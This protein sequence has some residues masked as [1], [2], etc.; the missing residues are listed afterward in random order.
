MKTNRVVVVVFNREISKN[1]FVCYFNT[2]K[3]DLEIFQKLE[4]KLREREFVIV[5][6]LFIFLINLTTISILFLY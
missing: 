2:H 4:N 5:V 1:L 6:C 3:A